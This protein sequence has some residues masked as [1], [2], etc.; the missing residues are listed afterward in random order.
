MK[1]LKATIA[2]IIFSVAFGFAQEQMLLSGPVTSGGFGGPVVKFGQFGGEWGV[3]TGGRGG[4][5]INHSITLGG[6]GYSIV[7]DVPVVGSPE[8]KPYLE[9]NY[10]GLEVGA[11]LHSDKLT[12]FSANI[13]FAGG[14]TGYRTSFTDEDYYK[15]VNNHYNYKK[16]KVFVLEP[17]VNLV[18]NITSFFRIGAGV[19]Y[20]KA[21][22]VEESFP[23]GLLDGASAGLTFKFGKF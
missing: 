11:I 4:W 19:S 23:D 2:I 15:D 17:T 5:I 10:G 6:G 21:F 9:L 1:L 16:D 13:L 14:E 7:N 22:G 20:R 12:H 3:L 8:D 18:V